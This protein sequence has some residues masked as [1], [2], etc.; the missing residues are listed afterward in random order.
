MRTNVLGD[1][2]FKKRRDE[3]EKL[4]KTDYAL[5]KRT[6]MTLATNTSKLI[7]FPLT[8]AREF[9]SK[10]IDTY[11][12]LRAEFFSVLVTQ[13]ILLDVMY[14]Y[15]EKG[16]EGLTL[17]DGY[18][19]VK[20]SS[21][22]TITKTSPYP[23]N[24]YVGSIAHCENEAYTILGKM[25]HNGKLKTMILKYQSRN[26]P[27]FNVFA[28]YDKLFFKMDAN[29]IS[30]FRN[31]YLT[32][33]FS[34]QSHLADSYGSIEAAKSDYEEAR[35]FFHEPWED[36]QHLCDALE[37]SDLKAHFRDFLR[38][39]RKDW[40]S[41]G[42]GF[43]TSDQKDAF[44]DLDVQTFFLELVDHYDEQLR[45]GKIAAPIRRMPTPHSHLSQA[46]HSE[47]P[48]E[49]EVSQHE[50]EMAHALSVDPDELHAYLSMSGTNSYPKHG[51]PEYGNPSPDPTQMGDPRQPSF[52]IDPRRDPPNRAPSRPKAK[53]TPTT[54]YG[55][56][57]QPKADRPVRSEPKKSKYPNDERCRELDEANA[58]KIGSVQKIAC[59]RK[60]LDALGNATQCGGPHSTNHC[61]KA[62]KVKL[63]MLNPMHP[64]QTDS[65]ISSLDEWNRLFPGVSPFV[66]ET[67]PDI[68]KE[69]SK[70]STW[71]LLDWTAVGVVILALLGAFQF[72]FGGRADACELRFGNADHGSVSFYSKADIWVFNF[73]FAF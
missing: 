22:G 31:V 61:D 18:G 72:N 65:P 69:E 57:N 6:D 66:S 45:D 13:Q 14:N 10:G 56:E 29:K 49:D 33:T 62:P 55:K 68:P 48:G 19:P 11:R 58:K 20:L 23:L 40:S 64:Y 71:D 43:T 28:F 5:P 60:I 27:V 59:R 36:L 37:N 41:A 1:N 3:I 32:M 47:Q 73:L 35:G 52:S 26:Q 51:S 15:L 4:E 50:I 34:S 46:F 12:N 53:E 67:K 70:R 16:T 21:L 30:R 25:V 44:E 54:S 24:P 42:K 2:P 38:S 8:G 39:Q 9:N 17:K 7:K 63:A